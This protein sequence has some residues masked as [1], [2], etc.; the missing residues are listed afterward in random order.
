MDWQT[1]NQE[2]CVLLQIKTVT[3]VTN[4]DDIL[5]VKGVEGIF[6]DPAD[7]SASMGYIE[8]SGHPEVQ[9]V[10]E[11]CISRIIATGKA[12]GIL[13]GD[14]ELAKHYIK[15]DALFVGVG[16]DTGLLLESSVSLAATFKPSLAKAKS[17]R[18]AVY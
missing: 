5:K 17:N 9:G 13:M 10:I 12:A 14:K 11:N 2:I 8:N 16:T 4:L 3:G 6:I 7:L 1:A 15:C 18:S